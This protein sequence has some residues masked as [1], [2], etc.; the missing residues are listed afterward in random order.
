[1]RDW[2]EALPFHRGMSLLGIAVLVPAAVI[3]GTVMLGGASKPAPARPNGPRDGAH[4]VAPRHT[5]GTYVPPRSSPRAPVRTQRGSV[6]LVRP[7]PTATRPRP[8]P[9]P[10]CPASLRQWS[11]L[12]EACIHSNTDRKRR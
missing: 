3:G 10:S 1:M 6:T 9:S 12:W 8:S 5:W 2:F 7:V 4:A 11:W